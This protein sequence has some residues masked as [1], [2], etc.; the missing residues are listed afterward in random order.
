MCADNRDDPRR[1]GGAST[2]V[3]EARVGGWNGHTNRP[4]SE[5]VEE[6]NAPEDTLHG[7]G[8]VPAWILRLASSDSHHLDTAV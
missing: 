8:N 1:A 6:E 3:Q 4:G 5:N 7:L 2:R